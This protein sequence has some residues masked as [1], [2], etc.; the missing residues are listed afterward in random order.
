MSDLRVLVTYADKGG[1]SFYRLVAP[2]RVLMSQ[3]M[4]VTLDYQAGSIETTVRDGRIISVSPLDYD[5]VVFQRP[6]MRNAADAI[7][8]VKE[9][10]IAVVVEL[11]DDYWNIQKA[12]YFRD[13]A[14]PNTSPHSNHRHLTRC[15]ELAD[16]VTVST[17]ALRRLIP[18][19]NV[20]VL[21]N[22]VPERYLSLEKSDTTEWDA[23][24]GK[25]LVGWSGTPETHAGD[26]SVCG[27]SVAVACR[28]HDARF[29]CIG[30][31]FSA[32][33]LGF[34]SGEALFSPW[35]DFENYAQAV[36]VFDVGIVP[37][38]LNPFNQSKSYLKGLEYAA[39]GI[40]FVASPTD[41]YTRLATSGVG[42]LAKEK[43]DWLRALNRIL[44]DEPFR[45]GLIGAGR[46]FAARNTYEAHAHQ[47]AEA[48]QH[49]REIG[50]SR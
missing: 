1:C 14:Q 50:D 6:L 44:D 40:P 22:M 49:A 10:G 34:E 29:L 41:E 12:N 7:T 16:L 28:N 38:I 25:T 31:E 20:R 4:D 17:P 39:L 42:I 45:A 46:E 43:H 26:L 36:T 9:Q 37:L 33:M 11:D 24:G 48:W 5:V 18:N 35:V 2:S 21:R 13:H 15:L 23:V 30:S 8:L 19:R 3:G 27:N 32:N 47:W